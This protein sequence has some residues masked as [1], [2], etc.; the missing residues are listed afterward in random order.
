MSSH[1]A[2]YIARAT[3]LVAFVLLT[4]SVV[5]GLMLST[6]L[7]GRRPPPAWLLDVHRMLSGLATAFVG[8][9]M[10][11]FLAD[12]W[13]D[14]GVADLLVPFAA[15][16]HPLA[17]AAGVVGFYL[18]LA[19]EL[20][21]LLRSRLRPRVWRLVHLL[22][23]VLFWLAALHMVAGTDA[24]NAVWRVV[25]VASV[26]AVMFLTLVRVLSGKGDPRPGNT[27][28]VRPAAASSGGSGRV[29]S[30]PPAV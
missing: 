2:W 25:G 18:L 10:V 13:L 3:G 5:L 8:V 24:G 28:G 17:M 27:G 29:A 30:S 15:D 12:S 26:A 19:V 11:A 16:W 21:S 14:F 20:T 7:A 9:H 23:Y 22:S 4:L 1:T 6:R